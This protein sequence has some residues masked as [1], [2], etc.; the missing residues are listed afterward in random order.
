MK[1][2]ALDTINI[3]I[4]ADQFLCLVSQFDSGSLGLPVLPIS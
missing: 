3:Y 1:S 4:Y 2:I